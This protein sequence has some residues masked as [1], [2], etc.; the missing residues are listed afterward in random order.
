MAVYLYLLFA[1][2]SISETFSQYMSVDVFYIHIDCL[3]A[4]SSF[5]DGKVTQ[6]LFVLAL[7]IGVAF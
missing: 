4:L 6:A 5:H 7:I 3:V 1:S 2:S